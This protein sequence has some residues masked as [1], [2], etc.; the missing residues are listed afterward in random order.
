MALFLTTV[1]IFG[2]VIFIM[3]IGVMVGNRRI[4]GS[5]GGPGGCDFC[6]RKHSGNGHCDL[7]SEGAPDES[8]KCRLD[9]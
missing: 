8:A 4:E 2:F 5:C 9:E 1:S 3:A 7:P 6:I